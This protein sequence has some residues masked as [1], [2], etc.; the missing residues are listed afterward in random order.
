MS[1]HDSAREEALLL[2]SNTTLGLLLFWWRGNRQ[3][4]GRTSL[5]GTGLEGLPV[6]DVRTLDTARL[7]V[8]SSIFDDF[9][10]KRFLPANEA[11]H[12]PTRKALDEAVL[13]HLL[14]L[15]PGTLE[16]LDLLRL[17]WCAEPSV[18]GGKH[19]RPPGVISD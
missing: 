19:T 7:R 13:L 12:D 10:G 17:K 16:P 4:G 8:A 14:S 11:Y 3:Q 9:A 5:T 18:H 6:F 2:W 1:A 15:P